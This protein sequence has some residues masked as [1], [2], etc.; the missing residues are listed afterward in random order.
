MIRQPAILKN[1]KYQ[2]ET[3]PVYDAWASD[4]TCPL[5]T[6]MDAAEHRHVNYYL[7]NSVM[8]PETRV[9]VNET[10][11]CSRH[12]PMMREAGYAHHLGL[13]GHTHLQT[14]RGK[15]A[16]K[17]KSLSRRASAKAAVEF[18]SAVRSQAFECLICRSMERDLKRYAYT[19]VMMYGNEDEF[20]S[21][22]EES[23]GPCLIHAADLADM[24][25]ETL[26]KNEMQYFL[27]ALAGHLDS[28][29]EELEADVLRFTQKFDTQ[30]D[31]MEWGNSRDAHARTVQALSG[32]VVR[33][34]D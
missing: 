33:L 21:L 26:K 15:M 27:A 17:L 23:P 18:S 19:A 16:G 30:N 3:I 14:V 13:V 9:L 6:L 24:A 32:R 28:A 31:G 7:G 29:L 5:C 11:F 20:H 4:A 8:N 2:L 1:V 34:K 25:V 12:F 22:F 10:G